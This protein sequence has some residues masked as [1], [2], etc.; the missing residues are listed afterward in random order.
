MQLTAHRGVSRLAPENTIAAFQ[1]AVD[2]KVPWIELD[3]QLSSDHTP[4]VIHDFTVNRCTN[5]RGKVKNLS[6]NELKKLD[7]GIWFGD[8]FENETIPTLE[9][10]LNL[11]KANNTSLNIELKVENDADAALLCAQVATLIEVNQIDQDLLLFSSFSTLALLEMKQRLPTI[12]RGQ[13]WRDLPK[14][15]LS[16]LNQ[17]DAYSVHCDYRFIDKQNIEFL[18]HENYRVFCYTVNFSELAQPMIAGGIDNIIT[19]CPHDLNI[20]K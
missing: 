10:V 20:Q 18:H 6:S 1:L 8:Q 12:R 11:V 19:D 2:F 13:L 4:M 3:V 16:V 14:D 9:Q 15:A 5:G 17:I 7:A